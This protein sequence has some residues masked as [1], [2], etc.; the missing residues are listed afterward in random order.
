MQ[1]VWIKAPHLFCNQ[2]V[3]WLGY[4]LDGLGFKSWQGKDIFIFSTTLRLALRPSQ[5]CLQIVLQFFFGEMG[6]G[7]GNAGSMWD[8]SLHLAVR[9]RMSEA[10]TLLLLYTFKTW[11]WTNLRLLLNLY[12]VMPVY[13]WLQSHLWMH[14]ECN[15]ILQFWDI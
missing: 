12:L 8:W 5:P 11:T 15:H 2:N 10:V 7:G 13:L 9:L 4:R 6:G 14:R 1:S 3:S